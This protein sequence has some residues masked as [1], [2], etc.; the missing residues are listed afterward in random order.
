MRAAVSCKLLLYADDSA[1]LTSCKDVSEIEGVLSRELESLSEW[2]EENRLS[3]HLG[4]TQSI[5]FG[6]KKL[7][8]TSNKLH[9]ECI[10]NDIELMLKSLT[11]GST[12][13]NLSLVPVL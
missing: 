7:L 12:W 1:L 3:L 2:V 9:V 11:S 10:G 4:K 6:S 13:I 8:R 5:L